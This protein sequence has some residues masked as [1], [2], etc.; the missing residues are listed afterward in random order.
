MMFFT[1]LLL[2]YKLH[3]LISLRHIDLVEI[4]MNCQGIT[5]VWLDSFDNMVLRFPILGT[6]QGDDIVY[7][8]WSPTGC[9]ST[10][11]MGVRLLLP[12]KLYLLISFRHTDLV[13]V[14]MDYIG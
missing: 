4:S 1:W 6:Q 9:K 10:K 7:K 11:R 14:S 2:P 13:E 8:L 12:Y 3:L 5:I